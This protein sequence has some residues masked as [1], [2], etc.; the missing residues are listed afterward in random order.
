MIF[1]FNVHQIKLSDIKGIFDFISMVYKYGVF[2]LHWNWM[3]II[4][5]Y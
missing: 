1:N 5:M 4:V 2:E 3:I